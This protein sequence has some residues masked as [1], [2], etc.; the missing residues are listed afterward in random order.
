MD[1][2]SLLKYILAYN[3]YGVKRDEELYEYPNA[4]M[5]DYWL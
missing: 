3:F 2:V 4:V 5:R 1:E